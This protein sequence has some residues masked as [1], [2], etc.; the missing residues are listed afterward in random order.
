MRLVVGALALTLLAT[1]AGSPARAQEVPESPSSVG[2]QA[3]GKVPLRV[4]RVMPASRQA[5]LY[6]R[7]R[8]THVLA[9]V[10]GKVGGYTVERID[11]DEV[12]LRLD[13]K[14]IVL[15]APPR[16]A[17]R[18]DAG[19]AGVPG[20]APAGGPLAGGPLAGAIS[21]GAVDQAPVD[22]YGDGAIRSVDGAIRNVDAPIDPYADPPIRSVRAPDAPAVAGGVTGG[23]QPGEGGV[24]VVRAPT[25][26][27][28]T[29]AGTGT[30]GS[31]GG[32]VAGEGGVRVASAGGA[33]AALTNGAPTT[34]VTAASELADAYPDDGPGSSSSPSSSTSTGVSTSPSPSTSTG[35]STSTPT[36]TTTLTGPGT[37]TGTTTPLPFDTVML[38]RREV[39][40]ALDHF[41]TLT[42]AIRG[43]FSAAGV[44]VDSVVEG[45]IFHRA[46]LRAGDVI[47]A[48]DGAKLRTLDDAANLYARAS[49]AKALTAH[50]VRSG[51]PVTLHVMIQ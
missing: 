27:E 20:R 25:G 33:N 29:P 3:Q 22:P 10:G 32:I 38:S 34:I 18:P 51:K 30:A 4:V 13:G 17:R 26:T 21:A 48:V 39:D 16:V 46:G 19:R 50:I 24:R 41:A 45:S 8:A 7:T 15:V 2:A 42:M 9:E 28:E 6:D 36:S 23:I 40:G 37:L 31:P 5:L 47:A 35:S 14:V 49:T 43:S 1:L 12:T 11:A 44:V